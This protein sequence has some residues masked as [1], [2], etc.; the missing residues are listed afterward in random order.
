MKKFTT[1][2]RDFMGLASA[3]LAS[4][5]M[6]GLARA[7]ADA[8]LAFGYQNTSWGVIGMIA[9][10]DDLFKKAGANVTIYKFDG[11]KATRDAMVA[12][13]IDIG[14]LGAT[15]FI[16]GAAKGN[17]AGI[18]MAMYAGKTLAVMA[19]A[20]SGITKV[21]ELKGKKV[22]SQLGSSTDS[23]FQNKVLPAFGLTAADV[24]VV[25]IPH[26]NHVSAMA[27][28]SVD[29]SALVE[30]Y[31]SVAEVEGLAKILVDYSKYDI[32]PVVLTAN[33][34][35]IEGKREA[36]V[37]FLRGWLAAVDVFNNEPDRTA[38][39]IK[40]HFKAQGFEFSDEVGKLMLSKVD[41]RTDYIPELTGALTTEA[42]TLVK[43]G[44]LAAVPDW[45]KLLDSSILQEARA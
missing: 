42:E 37:A 22:A 26:Q 40:N 28:G 14:V 6:P 12:G 30:P 25:N 5:A 16:V 2:R 13:R 34:T 38:E 11:G 3:G 43:N 32:T 19:G 18:G 10:A 31:V 23:V 29:A 7:Q 9:E 24:Q 15:P 20:N 1:S 39:I 27:A 44:Q 17:M 36:V 4:L 21:E 35:A 8:P 45:S 33:R 41:V